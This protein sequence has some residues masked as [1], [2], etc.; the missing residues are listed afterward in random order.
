MVVLAGDD[1]RHERPDDDVRFG[2]AAL[3][4]C[5]VRAAARRR[6][7]SAGA[8]THGVACATSV[9]AA[10]ASVLSH[11]AAFATIHGSRLCQAKL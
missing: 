7:R 4:R 11:A 2:A 9:S 1:A 6:T 3:P 10:V 8:V 5:V